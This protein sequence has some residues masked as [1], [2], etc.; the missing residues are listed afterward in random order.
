LLLNTLLDTTGDT[1]I[2]AYERALRFYAQD[3]EKI[4]P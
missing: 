3:I 1:S 2:R 4:W